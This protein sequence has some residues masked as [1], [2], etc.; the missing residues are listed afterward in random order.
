[1]SS[2]QKEYEIRRIDAGISCLVK[3]GDITQELKHIPI[4]SLDGFEIGYE[5][6][7][8]ADLALAILADY[9]NE[10]EDQ[11]RKGFD[12]KSWRLHQQFKSQFIA[13]IELKQF[14]KH[15]I[16]TGEIISWAVKNGHDDLIRIFE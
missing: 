4:H 15:T 5:G 12:T 16:N 2:L 9:F 7:G 14:G 11:I 13:S 10:T 6:S 3:D 1:M 8:P